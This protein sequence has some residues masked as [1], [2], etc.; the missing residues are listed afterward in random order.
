MLARF[1][2]ILI[3]ALVFSSCK[4]K[5][6]THVV[7][8]NVDS[9]LGIQVSLL[10]ELK[11]VTHKRAILDGKENVTKLQLK[12]KPAWE[13]ELAIFHEIDLVNKPVNRAYYQIEDGIR[14]TKSNLIIRSISTTEDLP[15][16]SLRVYYHGVPKNIKRL[17]AY[18]QQ[19]NSLFSS[20]KLLTL[21]FEDINSQ[22]T[23]TYFSIKGGQKM[24]M[25][26]SVQYH[27]EGSVVIP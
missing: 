1:Y 5:P 23:L 10:S 20:S 15:V 11:T 12:D 18:V 3:L 16:K 2:F 14:D 7:L 27:L 24:F 4:K 25:D 9:L 19:T 13:N 22:T 17:E 8:Y 26:D 6:E 21:G